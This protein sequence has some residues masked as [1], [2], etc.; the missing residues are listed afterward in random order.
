MWIRRLGTVTEE[1][2]RLLGAA[3]KLGV[4]KCVSTELR[5]LGA[6]FASTAAAAKRF[7][8]F[9]CGHKTQVPAAQCI[10]EMV[11]ACAHHTHEPMSR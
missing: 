6:P 4:T 1:I 2:P 5:G 11:G 10:R 7:D 9:R 8:H 3:C